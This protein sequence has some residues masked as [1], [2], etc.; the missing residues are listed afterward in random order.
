MSAESRGSVVTLGVFDG[1]H[2]GH[3]AVVGAAVEQARRL[4][5]PSILVTFDPHPLRVVASDRAPRLLMTLRERLAAAEAAGIDET[6]V[7]PFTPRFAN[8]TAERFVDDV[9]VEGLRARSVVV[10]ANF[11]FGRGN[12]GDVTLLREAGSR[13]GFAVTAVDLVEVDG[14][15]CSSTRVR[16]LLHDGDAA[17]ARELLTAD[18]DHAQT[19]QYGTGTQLYRSSHA[20]AMMLAGR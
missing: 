4:G 9:L 12:S 7:L 2:A 6:V 20:D 11:R 1:F 18:P 13:S 3:R 15:V 14:A 16:K 5:V 17:G 19:L 8:T 10:G